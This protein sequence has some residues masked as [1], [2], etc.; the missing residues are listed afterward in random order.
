M[1]G[2]HPTG[3]ILAGYYDGPV[4]GIDGWLEDAGQVQGVVGVMY[5]TWQH[6]YDDLE[7]FGSKLGK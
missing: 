4:D 2:D 7:A 5:T 6:R 3:K 1:Y